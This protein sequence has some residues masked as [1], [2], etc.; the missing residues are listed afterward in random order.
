M[1][2]R[3]I[4]RNPAQITIVS[5]IVCYAFSLGAGTGH[6]FYPLLPIIYEV[7]MENNIRP[8]RPMAVSTIASQQAITASPVSAAMAAMIALYEPLGFGLP[9]IMAIA[10]PATLIGVLV[11]AFVQKRIGKELKDD[12]EYNRR[13]QA[14][15]VHIAE[16]QEKGAARRELPKTAKI[17]ALLFLV[18]VAAVVLS[19]LFPVLPSPCSAG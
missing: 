14:G 13:L 8:E 6:V 3:I 16:G 1:A 10:V 2:E 19:G 9:K 18:A 15:L 12:P 17:S 7:A 5:P 11:A 4:R